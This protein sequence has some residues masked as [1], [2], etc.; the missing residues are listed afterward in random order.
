MTISPEN[1]IDCLRWR[2]ATKEFDPEKKIP[3]DT[4]AAIEQSMVLT[5]SSFGLQPWKFITVTNQETKTDLLEH[6]WH[7]RQTTDCSHMVVLCARDSMDQEDIEAWLAQLVETRG[8]TRE[9]LDGYAGMMTGFFGSM[10]PDKTLSWA[11]NQVYIALGQLLSTAA[12]LGVDA[13]PMEGIVP[14]EYDRILGLEGSGFSTTVACAM[15]FRSA[16]DKYAEL[17]KVRYHS[18]RVLETI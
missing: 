9:S 4:W 14:T 8:V 3:A 15:G 17:P 7:Q 6:S 10:D 12:V 1:L 2:Y 11:K 5:P 13:C 16:G 18:S